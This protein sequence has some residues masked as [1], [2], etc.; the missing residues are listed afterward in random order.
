MAKGS[1]LRFFATLTTP[2][3]FELSMGESTLHNAM[4][5]FLGSCLK[6]VAPKLKRMSA[7]FRTTAGKNVEEETSCFCSLK[8]G[9]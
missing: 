8:A 9:P 7:F 3:S 6:G 1:L 4:N 5:P 2:L